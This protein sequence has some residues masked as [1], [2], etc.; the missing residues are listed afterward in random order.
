MT[1]Q[2]Y[3]AALRGR[4][5]YV[6]LDLASTKDLTAL[7]GVFPDDEGFDVLCQCFVPEETI[8]ERER[9]DKVPYRQW[10]TMGPDILTATEGTVVDY[11]TVR[12]A[13]LGWDAEFDIRR[14]AYDPWNAT[15]LITRLTEQDGITCMPMRQGF[16]SLSAPTKSLEKAI[17][18]KR[19]RHDGHPVLRWCVGNVSVEQDA[20][21]NL[22]PSK[23]KSTERIDAVAAL[24]MALDMMDRYHG[25]V[26]Q[27]YQML[28]LGGR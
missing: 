20:S 19:L 8:P 23:K 28:I 6:G 14:L 7:V 9:T 4:P 18:S 15:D 26:S 11:E 16:A 17:L 2:E 25:Q 21:G 5:C 27:A 3:R 13:I 12:R 10:V 1:R 24:V 22:K